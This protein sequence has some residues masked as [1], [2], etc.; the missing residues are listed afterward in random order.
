MELIAFQRLFLTM[1][2]NFKG[3]GVEF[4]GHNIRKEIRNY[5]LQH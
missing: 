1:T 3:F 2:S 4:S 5:D